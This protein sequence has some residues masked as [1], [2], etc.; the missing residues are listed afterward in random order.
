LRKAK[1]AAMERA[2]ECEIDNRDYL[3]TLTYDSLE[4]KQ[5]ARVGTLA[6]ETNISEEAV[7]TIFPERQ[8]KER[9]V[10]VWQTAML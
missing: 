3:L 2:G 9:C 8:V 7:H 6:S 1:K 4:V 10:F 5:E